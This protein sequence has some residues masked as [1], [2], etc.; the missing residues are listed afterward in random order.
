MNRFKYTI[1]CLIVLLTAGIYVGFSTVRVEKISVGMVSKM[2]AKG[3]YV[4]TKAVVYYNVVDGKMVTHINSPFE[5]IIIVDAKG[6]LKTYD[7][8]ENLV[9][10]ERDK[11]ISSKTSFFYSFFEGK[12]ADMGLPDLNFKKGSTKREGNQLIS[13]WKPKELMNK[14]L[15]KIITAHD[16]NLPIFIGFYNEQK[17][18]MQKIYYTNYQT[19]GG[20]MLPF[21]ITEIAYFNNS[22]DSII[23]RR[24]YSDLKINNEVEL[25]YLN[26]VIP[27]NAKLI[28]LPNK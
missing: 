17:K 9:S 15:Q 22:K 11:N 5:Q 7:V 21:T 1:I 27:S 13:E 3:K 14:G 20:L 25:K 2:L 4:T 26:F 16:N 8:S 18:P 24:I 10:I 19:A 28:T 6:E 23:T 12:I